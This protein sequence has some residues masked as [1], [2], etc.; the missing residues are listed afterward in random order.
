MQME[1]HHQLSIVTSK[2]CPFCKSPRR[3][4]P[5]LQSL[6]GTRIQRRRNSFRAVTL[7]RHFF[8]RCPALPQDPT[9]ETAGRPWCATPR[10]LPR[11]PAGRT[12]L[13]PSPLNRLVRSSSASCG[14]ACLLHGSDATLGRACF[15]NMA[16]HAGASSQPPIPSRG[17]DNRRSAYLPRC[18]PQK[19]PCRRGRSG[20][21]GFHPTLRWE[22]RG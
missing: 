19:L 14:F 5:V 22:A 1:S 13:G 20:R 9:L 8:G 16:N 11:T 7:L 10:T 2:T 18:D 6:L 12:I 17:P 4:V 21:L 3:A 15:P